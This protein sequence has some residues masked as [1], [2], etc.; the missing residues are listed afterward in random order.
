MGL[1]ELCHLTGVENALQE[2]ADLIS[3]GTLKKFP[4]MPLRESELIDDLLMKKINGFYS[5]VMGVIKRE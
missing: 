4:T 5:E 3:K 2:A 1:F